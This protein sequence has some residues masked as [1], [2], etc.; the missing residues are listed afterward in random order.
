M[1][2]TIRDATASDIDTI[3]N[4]NSRMA[5]ET[6]SRSLDK[7]IIGPGVARLIDDNSKG[8]YWVA[9]LGGQLIGQIMVTYEWSDW[10]NGTFWWI[11]SVYI[12]AEYRRQGVFSALYRHVQS[13]AKVEPD[14]VGVRLY[15]END[16]K[17]A[18]RVYESLGMV[19][20]GYCVM[21]SMF[22]DGKS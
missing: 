5:V 20:P 13:L 16:N 21:E 7:N 10:R 17:R 15:V 18:Q 2:M 4:F 14:V 11:Q 12:H 6:E 9:D 22:D 3:A 19:Y 1:V 8:R